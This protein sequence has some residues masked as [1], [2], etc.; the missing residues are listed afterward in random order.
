[1]NDTPYPWKVHDLGSDVETPR[2][3]IDAHD[4]Q[5][6][7]LVASVTRPNDAHLISAAPELLKLLK[8]AVEASK[9]IG[10]TGS[11]LLESLNAIA[12]AEGRQ[13]A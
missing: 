10:T 8:E 13:N 4:N 2:F 11:W 9:R 3:T 1:M 6:P 5:G 7:W 12:K